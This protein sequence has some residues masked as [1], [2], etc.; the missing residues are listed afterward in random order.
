[1]KADVELQ[2]GGIEAVQAVSTDST[3]KT[4]IDLHRNRSTLGF[5][6]LSIILRI[7]AECWFVYVL[8][9]WNLAALNNEPYRCS[10]DICSELYV[11]VV[12][13][14]PEKCMSIYALASISGMIIVCS[15]LFCM[16]AIVHYLCNF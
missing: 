4:S 1:M 10:T 15:V 16:Y 12:N 5:Y 8:L 13:A 2:G 14:A 11:C 9:S 3:G 7:L 6:L